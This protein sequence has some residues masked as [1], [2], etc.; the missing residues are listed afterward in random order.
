MVFI[1]FTTHIASKVSVQDIVILQPA[2]FLE[3]NVIAVT[4]VIRVTEQAEMAGSN[5]A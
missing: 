4:L 5:N 2:E 3:S 1:L